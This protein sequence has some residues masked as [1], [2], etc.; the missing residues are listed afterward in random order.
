MAIASD[1]QVGQAS[2]SLLTE[3]PQRRHS[4]TAFGC[5]VQD[6]NR[7]TP[8][9]SID[10]GS[11]AGFT[12]SRHLGHSAYIAGPVSLSYSTIVISAW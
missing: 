10:T 2:V 7:S 1:P 9:N 12:T 6:S 11:H 5:F 4:Y 3:V 8:S